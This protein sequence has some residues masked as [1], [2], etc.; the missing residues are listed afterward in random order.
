MSTGMEVC[1]YVR[2]KVENQPF[3]RMVDHSAEWSTWST[4]LQNGRPKWRTRFSTLV[5]S[6]FVGL[7][8]RY[9]GSFSTLVDFAILAEQPR[10]VYPDTTPI[11]IPIRVLFLQIFLYIF[12]KRLQVNKNFLMWNKTSRIYGKFYSILGSFI[13]YLEIVFPY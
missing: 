13:P 5:D 1:I 4:I 7:V 11:L 2:T 6:T 8:V 12:L 3:C 10:S 9:S